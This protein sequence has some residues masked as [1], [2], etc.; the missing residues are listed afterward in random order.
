M[1]EAIENGGPEF[2]EVRMAPEITEAEYKDILLPAID[3]AIEQA[4]RVRLLLQLEAGFGDFTAGAMVQDA[5]L[6][7]KHWRGFDRCAMVTDDAGM[8]RMFG[9]F[10]AFMPCPVALFAT[11]EVE[12]ARRWLRESLGSIQI[13]SLGSNTVCVRLR[14]KL[15]GNMY[16]GK[17]DDLDNLMAPMDGVG[18]VIDLRDFDGWQGLGALKDHFSLAHQH[19]AQIRRAAIVGDAGWQ[20]MAAQ[21]GKHVVGLDA[22]H[23]DAA[24]FDA[25]VTWVSETD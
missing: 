22:K 11:S 5:R 15:D 6:G 2:L 25:A 19:V 4:D 16:E 3:R 12:D 23:F 10:S 20:A 18:L 8:R 1:I 24:A 7:F 17:S 14:G 21:F 13:D 9:L